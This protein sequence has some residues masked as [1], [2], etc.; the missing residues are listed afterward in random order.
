LPAPLMQG[1]LVYE[2][3]VEEYLAMPAERI[4]AAQIKINEMFDGIPDA[5]AGIPNVVEDV[6][7]FGVPLQFD[8]PN[9]SPTLG[10]MR[11]PRF[12][13]IPSLSCPDPTKSAELVKTLNVISALRDGIGD[14]KVVIGAC[15]APFSLP[16]MLMGTA[17]WMRLLFT[18]AFR[19][20]Y[21]EHILR[22]CHE[23]VVRWARAQVDAGAHVIVLADGMASATMLPRAVF[24]R[25]ALPAIKQVIADIGGLVAYEAVGRAEPFID[26]LADT[27]AVA[28]LIGEEDDL[29]HCKRATTGRCGLIGNINN[30]K[31]RRWS[32]ARVEL[33]AKTAL[34]HGMPGYGFALANQGPEIPFD[35]SLECIGALIRAVEKYG[36]YEAAAAV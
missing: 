34:N 4:A 15:I 20:R 3:S 9:S 7:A 10:R 6:A 24:E 16:S 31:M 13:D 21:F 32:A 25:F 1:A 23:F 18:K 14:E 12:E 29:Q 26:L 19:E 30:M 2:C 35:T 8:Y 28:L 33:K 5:V 22:V 11:L 36:R 17:G 27:G